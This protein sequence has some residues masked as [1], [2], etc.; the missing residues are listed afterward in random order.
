MS[1]FRHF[2]E[3]LMAS[4][5]MLKPSYLVH[6]PPFQNLWIRPCVYIYMGHSTAQAKKSE[7]LFLNLEEKRSYTS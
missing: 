4:L 5:S 2:K 6:A 1:G 7:F 3:F